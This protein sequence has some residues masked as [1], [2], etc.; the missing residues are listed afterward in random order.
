MVSKRHRNHNKLTKRQ[1]R[2]KGGAITDEAST[3]D[4]MSIIKG[5]LQPEPAMYHAWILFG[6]SSVYILSVYLT[7]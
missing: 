5:K 1:K 2:Q 4:M 3:P 7:K 6:I